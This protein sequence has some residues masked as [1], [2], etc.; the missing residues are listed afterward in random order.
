MEKDMIQNNFLLP[1]NLFLTEILKS[2]YLSFLNHLDKFYFLIDYLY[3]K[4]FLDKRYDTLNK[5]EKYAKK[6]LFIPVNYSLLRKFIPA[7]SLKKIIEIL[8]KEKIIET[9][10]Q[11]Y[12]GKKSKGYRLTKNYAFTSFKKIEINDELVL[13]SLQENIALYDKNGEIHYSFRT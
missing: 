10:N 4:R 11:Y 12:V 9:D 3:E 13:N 2:K 5:R 8:L 6:K 1:D 7:A